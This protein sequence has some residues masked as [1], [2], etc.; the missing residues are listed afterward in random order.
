M[1]ANHPCLVGGL[2]G[3]A[4]GVALLLPHAP[5]LHPPT[6]PRPAPLPR[7]APA[8][9]CVQVYGAFYRKMSK[10]VQTELAE[11]NSVAE[12]ALSTMTTV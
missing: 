1:R 9:A 10:K 2:G 5:A 4:T 6:H 8:P 3:R 11:A 12:E 7:S